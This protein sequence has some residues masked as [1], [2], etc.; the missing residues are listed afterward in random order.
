MPHPY[1]DPQ[2]AP[3]RPG[4]TLFASLLPVEPASLPEWNRFFR[5]FPAMT[6]PN[7]RLAS[8]GWPAPG[9]A[10]RG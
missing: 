9:P 5:L 10:R 1:P 4:V 8:F 3:E 2:A 6:G 7:L